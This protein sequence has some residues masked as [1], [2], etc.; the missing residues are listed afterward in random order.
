MLFLALKGIGHCTTRV[1]RPQ[2]SLLVACAAFGRGPLDVVERLRRT[3]L[4]EHFR[5]MERVMERKKLYKAVYEM[6]VAPDACL[7]RHNTRRPHQ[8]RNMQGRTPA[9]AFREGLPR[10]KPTREGRMK[11]SRLESPILGAAT[12]RRI[13]Y[14]YTMVT[15]W[16]RDSN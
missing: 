3:L 6:R 4:D 16:W 5:V 15:P 13:P 11:K 7:V 12:V 8:G 10:P 1:T 9:R 2:S 14:L